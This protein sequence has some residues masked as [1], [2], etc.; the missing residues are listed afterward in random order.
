MVDKGDEVAKAEEKVMSLVEQE[1]AKNPDVAVTE[2]FEKAKSAS[3]EMKKLTL[4]QF[5]ARFPLQVKRKKNRA[6]GGGKRRRATQ[7]RKGRGSEIDRDAVRSAF[8]SFAMAVTAAEEK[9]DLVKVL[10]G[11]DR[12][13]DDAIKSFNGK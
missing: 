7:R 8:L 9:K 1:L 6:A 12:Y 3:P 2:L 4:R 10:A 5:N 11:V 13:V